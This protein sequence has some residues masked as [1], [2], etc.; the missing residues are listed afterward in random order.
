MLGSRKKRLENAR[1]LIEYQ[2]GK[3]GGFVPPGKRAKMVKTKQGYKTKM[4]KNELLEL[5]RNQLI[6][7]RGL[8]EAQTYR[9][10]ESKRAR[11]V[12]KAVKDYLNNMIKFN[13]KRGKPTAP[14][15]K[16]LKSIDKIVYKIMNSENALRERNSQKQKFEQEYERAFNFGEK[17]PSRPLGNLS[18]V[19]RVTLMGMGS[20]LMAIAEDPSLF[21]LGAGMAAYASG[22]PL[23]K[24][25]YKLKESQETIKELQK[26]F[27]AR[28]KEINEQLK[29]E[30]KR[31]KMA[32]KKTA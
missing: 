32:K 24:A 5:E 29:K 10:S 28:I 19:T 27:D 30:E 6:L 8:L 12:E 9:L 22:E 2:E 13:K 23:I 4:N 14:I 18:T 3:R 15:E 16:Q 26:K 7:Q 21:G 11:K 25:H 20:E 31:R 17:D 1:R